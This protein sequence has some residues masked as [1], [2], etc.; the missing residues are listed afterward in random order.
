MLSKL[1]HP[2]LTKY[3]LIV[4]VL[5]AA[6]SGLGI[7]TYHHEV[8]TIESAS[9]F[10]IVKNKHVDSDMN[11]LKKLPVL[12]ATSYKAQKIAEKTSDMHQSFKDLAKPVTT[13]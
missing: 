7:L 9:K 13:K 5:I 2:T 12:L 6:I 8:S 1:K 11:K 10:S 3:G 4:T